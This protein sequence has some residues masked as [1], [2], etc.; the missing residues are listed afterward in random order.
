MDIIIYVIWCK[1]E[2]RSIIETQLKALQ[3]PYNVN[4]FEASV[5]ENSSDF[6]IP[7]NEVPHRLQCCFR[8]HIRALHDFVKTYTESTYLLVLEDD[9]NLTIDNFVEKLQNVIQIY[10]KT[11]EIDYVSLGY[12]PTVLK[13]IP[14]HLKV[15]MLQKK[16]NVYYDFKHADFTIWGSQGQLFSHDKARK[17]VE[18]LYRDT[19]KQ[20]LESMEE[21]LTKHKQH[22]NK[23]HHLMIDALLPLL[24]SQAVVCPP[25]LIENNMP[26]TIHG[27]DRTSLWKNCEEAGMFSLKDFYSSF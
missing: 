7:D 11:P 16:E 17:I 6:I 26:S 5:P 12:L 3:I 21:Y 8:S 25:L 19:G 15:D 14:L 18:V 2:R 9:V 20:V 23:C 4:Y 10:E 24:F 22:Q 27:N 13:V 1:E